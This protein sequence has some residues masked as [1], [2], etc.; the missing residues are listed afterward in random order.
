MKSSFHQFTVHRDTIPLNAFVTSSGL[1]EWLKMPQGSSA[2]LRWFC[3]VVNE[4][5]KNFRG[6]A[7]YLDD[8]IVF[9]DTPAT[10][11]GTMHALFERLRT[12][13]LKLTP[14]KATIGASKADFLGHTISP[15]GVRL[16]GAK[17]SALTKLP[18][19]KDVKQLC[20]L[21]GGLSYYRK[22]LPNMA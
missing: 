14:P 5:I 18:M 8:L 1:F 20:S 4:V 9:D 22:F 16:N 15:D 6:V 13:N 2:A 3:N 19:P 11:V 17:V 10:H 7:S 12:H 21:L